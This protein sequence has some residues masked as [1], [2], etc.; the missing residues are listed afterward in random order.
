MRFKFNVFYKSKG[1]SI[2]LNVEL[3]SWVYIFVVLL[4][5]CVSKQQ[6]FQLALF[7]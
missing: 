7:G 6:S 5:G 1:F 3:A 2:E 4:E